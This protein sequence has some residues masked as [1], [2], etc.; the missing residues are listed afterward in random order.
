MSEQ[1]LRYYDRELAYLRGALADYA[2][3]QPQHAAQLKIN[4]SHIEDPNIARLI[5]AMALLSA[6]TEQRLDKRFPELAQGL[7]SV[8]YPGYTQSYPSYCAVTLPADPEQLSDALT[9]PAGSE[10][11]LPLDTGEHCLFST[12]DALNIQPFMLTQVAAQ[13]APFTG[14]VPVDAA[15]AEAVIELQLGLLRP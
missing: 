11:S 4:Q 5:D 3:R 9:L 13:A 14:S 15:S 12:C 1:L 10:L 6:K 8:L 2:Q 7:L